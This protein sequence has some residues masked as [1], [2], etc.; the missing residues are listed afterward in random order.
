MKTRN[1]PNGDHSCSVVVVCGFM[2][3]LLAQKQV[4]DSNIGCEGHDCDAKA[5]KQA[6]EH[7]AVGKD[8]AFAPGLALC[9]RV[10]VQRQ[11][12]GHSIRKG[13]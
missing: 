2:R 7:D 5:R 3:L 9:P 8:W 12:F 1:S 13:G 10:S 4:I 11:V 6:A